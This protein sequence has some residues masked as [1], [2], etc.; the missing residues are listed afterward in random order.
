MT[1]NKAEKFALTT[2]TIGLIADGI[3]IASFSGIFVSDSTSANQQTVS[4]ITTSRFIA[5]SVVY[6]W[7]VLSWF[8][9]RRAYLA[10][11]KKSEFVQWSYL[12]NKHFAHSKSLYQSILGSVFG[13]AI[14][15]SPFSFMFLK[16]FFITA[17]DT[18]TAIMTT[19]FVE[20]GIG[21]VICIVLILSMPI[22][23]ED[24]EAEI[25]TMLNFLN[26]FGSHTL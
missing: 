6:C 21:F 19:I 14:V 13:L 15:L 25:L 12:K 4:N 1:M 18:F 17:T 9:T 20:G 23:Y 8:L 7:L 5:L 24:I 3:T 16:R 10:Y 2:A 11:C 26:P 22:I